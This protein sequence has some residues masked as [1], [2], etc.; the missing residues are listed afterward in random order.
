MTA[1]SP[2]PPRPLRV[3]GLTLARDGR[4]LF[5]GISFTVEPGGVLLVRGPIGAG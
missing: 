5:S 2:F 1:E 4:T 3:S